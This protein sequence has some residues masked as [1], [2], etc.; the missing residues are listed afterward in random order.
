LISTFILLTYASETDYFSDKSDGIEKIYTEGTLVGEYRQYAHPGYGIVL[1]YSKSWNLFIQKNGK[2]KY[3]SGSTPHKLSFGENI[4]I[5][6][7]DRRELKSGNG[8]KVGL[9][10]WPQ[11]DAPLSDSEI[12]NRLKFTGLD[13]SALQYLGMETIDGKDYPY[14]SQVGG[15]SVERGSDLL[16]RYLF[17]NRG[18][19]FFAD[20]RIYSD[21]KQYEP[22]LLDIIRSIRFQ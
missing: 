4:I 19:L 7:R 10:I 5:T 8:I 22:L 13:P 9:T 11:N 2:K 16:K 17:A 20:Y 14:F 21:Q 18:I 12:A 15:G 6:Q 1:K 3:Q